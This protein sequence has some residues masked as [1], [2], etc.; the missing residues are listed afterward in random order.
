M[1]KKS[2]KNKM[3]VTKFKE[4][5]CKS[6]GLCAHGFNPKFCFKT[7]Y[8]RNPDKF[9]NVIKYK[10]DHNKQFANQLVELPI[11]ALFNN[12]VTM[13][14]F[15]S[16]FCSKEICVGCK[17]TPD[18][19]GVCLTKFKLQTEGNRRLKSNSVKK[20][21]EPKIKEIPKVTVFMSDNAAFRAEVK[22]ILEDF[23]KQ[24]NKDRESRQLVEGSTSNTTS[25][26]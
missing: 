21:T 4:V 9:I 23:N 26:Q 7:L 3:D 6:C 2:R 15:R 8:K 1:S 19:I 18:D 24:S 13:T 22:R 25:T 5:V 12:M 11:E 16:I 10:I 17:I 20:K 14:V